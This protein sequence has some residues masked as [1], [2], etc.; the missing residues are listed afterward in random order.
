MI[1]NFVVFIYVKIRKKITP[2]IIILHSKLFSFLFHLLSHC[3][4]DHTLKKPNSIDLQYFHLMK[5]KMKEETQKNQLNQNYF[6]QTLYKDIEIITY[7]K[8]L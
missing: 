1:T 2:C 8:Y 5:L 3:D 4:P 6:Y 7:E